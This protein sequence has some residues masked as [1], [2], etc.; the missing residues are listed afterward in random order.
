MSKVKCWICDHWASGP[1][2]VI[3]LDN[4]HWVCEDCFED[5]IHDL[6]PREIADRMFF[7]WDNADNFNDPIEHSGAIW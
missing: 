6:S 1:D 2:I 4:E 3:H 7:E 5:F